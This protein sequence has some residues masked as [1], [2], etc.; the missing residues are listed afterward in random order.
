MSEFNE[1]Q[2]NEQKEK[3]DSPKIR[4]GEN[5]SE[6]STWKK[7]TAKR[8]VFPAI[9]VVAVAIILSLMWVYQGTGDN[10]LELDETGLSLDGGGVQQEDGSEDGTLPV[11]APAEAMRWPVQHPEMMEVAMPYF[12]PAAEQEEKQAAIIEYDNEFY[13]SVG[14][15]LTMQ[16]DSSFDVLAAMSGVVTRV[17]KQPLIGNI[18]E[19]TH[20]N[21]LVTYYQ[22]LS[23]VLVTQ[24]EQVELG[25]VIA[26]AGRNEIGKDMG[27]HL[28]FEVRE[29][30]H[31]VNPESYLPPRQSSFTE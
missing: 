28:H 17:D 9:Y 19:I 29:N 14:I 1:Q 11:T 18:V 4:Q 25:Q 6:V 21:G 12:D 20:E 26:K 24:D 15:S 16:D 5:A 10:T 30:D 13:P 7:L 23:D 8:W 2:G 31:P 27:N 22:S 3:V